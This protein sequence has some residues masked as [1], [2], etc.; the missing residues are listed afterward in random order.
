VGIGIVFDGKQQFRSILED[1]T[2]CDN[3]GEMIQGSFTAFIDGNLTIVASTRPDAVIGDQFTLLPSLTNVKAGDN[4]FGIAL[5]KDN[6]YA[7]GA[8][9]SSGYREY[10]SASD[11]YANSITAMIFIPLGNAKEIDL[12]IAE[13]NASLH[14]E[15]KTNN[16]ITTQHETVEYATFYVGSDWLGLPSKAV[17][18]ALEP[19]KIRLVPDSDSALEGLI[20]HHDAVI[21]IFN[22]PKAFGKS[23]EA[24]G[25]HKQII[26]LAE[27]SSSPKFGIIV[28]A[29][30]EIPSIDPNTIES[31]D[32]LFGNH[33]QSVATGI[34]SLYSADQ[35]TLM[36]TI[37]APEKIWRMLNKT[38]LPSTTQQ[39]KDMTLAAM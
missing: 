3:R 14:N 23:S 1:V 26:V 15:F 13:D 9:G 19:E 39:L 7:V 35:K 12:L 22:M 31:N 8:Y 16:N 28:T 24:S 33:S 36:L 6:Y 29:L 10:K 38:N 11:C 27:T 37:V 25:K 30:G 34:T 32:S 4:N 5:Y 20:N 17:V 18:E 2:P 21:P